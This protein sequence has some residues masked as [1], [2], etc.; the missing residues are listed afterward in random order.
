[1]ACSL[2]VGMPHACSQ[3]SPPAE[4]RSAAVDS[5]SAVNLPNRQSAVQSSDFFVDQ[6]LK[7]FAG[8]T[9]QQ[10]VSA[11]PRPYV[12]AYPIDEPPGKLRGFA[13]KF[14]DGRVLDV[15]ASELKF[16]EKFSETADWKVQDFLRE[17]ITNIEVRR[18]PPKP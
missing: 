12:D 18:Y 14:A 8:K 1:M 11:F 6:N 9:V 4:R 16:V 13:F 5:R 2:L 15:Y 3:P 7:T 17:T 10:L